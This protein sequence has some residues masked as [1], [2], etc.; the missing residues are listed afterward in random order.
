MTNRKSAEHMTGEQTLSHILFKNSDRGSVPSS[1]TLRVSVTITFA[2]GRTS[3]GSQ[4]L[5]SLRGFVAPGERASGSFSAENGRQPRKVNRNKQAVQWTVA[6]IEVAENISH[7]TKSNISYWLKANI[8]F[9]FSSTFTITSSW[10]SKMVSAV[11]SPSF[12][13]TPQ[14][15]SAHR[16]SSMGISCTS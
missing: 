15:T 3:E 10:L 8:S 13:H 11:S 1:H 14:E 5:K 7:L 2:I 16:P 9:Y 4:W 12:S 6:S